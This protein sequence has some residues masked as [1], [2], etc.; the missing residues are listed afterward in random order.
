MTDWARLGTLAGM[1]NDAHRSRTLRQPR[2][3]RERL[4]EG[5]VDNPL[6]LIAEIVATIAAAHR[7]SRTHGRLN[8]SLVVISG[9]KG[10]R[11]EGWNA[12]GLA[13]IGY[14]APEQV[15]GQDGGARADVFALGAMAYEILAGYPPFRGATPADVAIATAADAPDPLEVQGLP[16]GVAELV[17]SCLAKRSDARPMDAIDVAE[18]LQELLAEPEQ[19]PTEDVAQ[20]AGQQPLAM[21]TDEEAPGAPADEVKIA[22]P[23]DETRSTPEA[24]QP[25]APAPKTVT[26]KPVA[27]G[28]WGLAI[29]GGV[30]V[31]AAIA[32]LFWPTSPQPVPD[33]PAEPTPAIPATPP[34][35]ALPAAVT[36]VSPPDAPTPTA[37]P[38]AQSPVDLAAD[39]TETSQSTT[40]PG[41]A[42]E[43]ADPTALGAPSTPTML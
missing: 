8:P 3:L 7:D 42:S 4:D 27:R 6:E 24:E 2:T 30:V 15:A 19:A 36:A 14:A 43:L 28:S 23:R 34:P 39:A 21:A 1:A 22:A 31:V 18:A 33:E 38:Q 12:R 35:T 13:A 5:P 20:A 29:A 16:S 17:F 32:L 10:V 40:L 25:A 41:A 11:I 26:A 9:E 37:L